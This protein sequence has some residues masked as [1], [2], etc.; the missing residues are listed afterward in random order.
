[1]SSFRMKP[2]YEVLLWG[3]S[4]C[5]IGLAHLYKAT[6]A[7]L[8]RLHYKAGTLNAVKARLKELVGEKYVQVSAVAVKHEGEGRTFF[9]AR[10]FY[11]LAPAGVRY[12][13]NLGLDVPE[14]WKPHNEVDKHGLFVEHTLEVN[15]MI[16]A[17]A[18]LNRVD[19]RF[20]LEGFRHERVLKQGP[21]PVTLPSG[22][23]SAVVPDAHLHF[24]YTGRHAN[25]D[26]SVLL[27]HDRDTEEK[28]HFTR[29]I[30][31]YVAFIKAGMYAG[32]NN[33][34]YYAAFDTGSINVAFSTFD[35]EERL[36]KI[37]KWTRSVLAATNE[38]PQVYRAFRFAALPRTP[39][40]K[41]AWLEPRWYYPDENKPPTPLLAA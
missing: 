40:P 7:Q 11:T 36:D 22:R 12:V 39:D 30:Q 20:Q 25:P 38:P 3:S 17:A 10:Y 29:K 4:R 5:H 41:T 21:I 28:A 2:M 26:F 24:S 32:P 19:P 37:R 13:A 15:D 1:M 16:I 8:T 35:G 6:P 34:P 14:S 31:A 33:K 18:L 27:E 23:P 9:T